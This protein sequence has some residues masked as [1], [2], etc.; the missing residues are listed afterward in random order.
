VPDRVSWNL[1]DAT[2]RSPAC[3]R[4]E[5]RGW[6][7]ECEGTTLSSVYPQSI[8][9][10][11]PDG[12]CTTCRGYGT[13]HARPE[14]EQLEARHRDRERAIASGLADRAVLAMTWPWS[15]RTRHTSAARRGVE[16]PSWIEEVVRSPDDRYVRL[17]AADVIERDDGDRARFIRA[18]L[19][20]ERALA[21]VRT[22]H[23]VV[24]AIG[25]QPDQIAAWSPELAALARDRVIADRAFVRGFIEHVT[26]RAS[27]FIAHAEE[28]FE[29]APIRFL[30]LTYVAEVAVA[31]ADSPWLAKIRGL[32]MPRAV[33]R[34]SLDSARWHEEP[35]EEWEVNAID[36]GVVRALANSPHLGGLEYLDLA[37]HRGVSTAHWTRLAT[38]APALRWVVQGPIQD[39]P[40]ARD[41][42]AAC[43]KHVAWFPSRSQQLTSWQRMRAICAGAPL[44]DQLT[45]RPRT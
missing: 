13:A 39:E 5:G 35:V 24:Q 17:V 32:R 2:E 4:C 25:P 19:D 21:A 30:T 28:V 45:P 34:P 27:D 31:V 3:S 38:A 29:R 16:I 14:T 40:Q 18:Q 43:G 15:A 33:D 26:M 12:L 11:C 37:L 9:C 36:D 1:L 7:L 23:E 20:E 44:E 10:S 8:A 6:C 41:V 42:E 22:E